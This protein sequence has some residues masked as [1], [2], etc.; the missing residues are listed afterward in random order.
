LRSLL[1]AR[2]RGEREER[3]DFCAMIEVATGRAGGVGGGT[4][5]TAEGKVEARDGKEEEEAF[6]CMT[7]AD[8]LFARD[9]LAP[10]RE[11]KEIAEFETTETSAEL[12]LRIT[13]LLSRIGSEAAE[14]RL[15]SIQEVG[16]RTVIGG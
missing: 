6:G 10:P 15:D 2:K 12:L 3:F 4:F 1:F 13:T 5:G 7:A 11:G 14:L 16:M 9:T 8:A